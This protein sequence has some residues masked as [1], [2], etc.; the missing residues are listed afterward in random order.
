[1]AYKYYYILIQTIAAM[2]LQYISSYLVTL[3]YDYLIS[4]Q[5]DDERIFGKCTRKKC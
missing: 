2:L 3:H 4:I 5:D 1:M